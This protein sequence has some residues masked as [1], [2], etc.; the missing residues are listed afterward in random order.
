MA[1]SPRVFGEQRAKGAGLG[2][3]REQGLPLRLP[4]ASEASAG[5]DGGGVAPARASSKHEGP[6]AVTEGV[7]EAGAVA[8]VRAC[9]RAARERLW[10]QDRLTT[11]RREP[12]L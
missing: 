10:E 1:T 5:T 11:K 2:R 4:V 9:G 12:D 6:G 7:A 3:G 8:G